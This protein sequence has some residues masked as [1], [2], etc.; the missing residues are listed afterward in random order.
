MK[1]IEQSMVHISEF[2]RSPKVIGLAE[3][4]KVVQANST[5]PK[6]VAHG[7]GGSSK[8]HRVTSRSVPSRP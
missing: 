1:W 7:K 4:L 5:G 6:K 8:A 2:R 3:F